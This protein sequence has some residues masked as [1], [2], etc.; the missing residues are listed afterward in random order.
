MITTVRHHISEVIM[1][2]TFADERQSVERALGKAFSEK[3]WEFL[4]RESYVAD[5]AYI[6]EEDITYAV[7]AARSIVQAGTDQRLPRAPRP[8]RSDREECSRA[9]AALLAADAARQEDVVGLRARVGSLLGWDHLEAWLDAQVDIDGRDRSSADPKVEL[10]YALPTGDSVRRR[11]VEAVGLL[12]E[13][14]HVSDS[15]ANAYGWQEAQ[16]L[17]WVLTGIVPLNARMHSDQVVH[18][19]RLATTDRIVLTIDPATP[20]AEVAAFYRRA[21][22]PRL[23]RTLSARQARLAAFVAERPKE[24]WQRRMDA[25]NALHP[26]KWRYDHTSN[27]IRD[28]ALAR[29]RLLRPR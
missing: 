29:D 10:A 7:N 1:R 21:R 15:L 6:S 13:L 25:W 20:A 24:P 11:R 18:S 14:A 19:P 9:I 27:M 16:A 12:A 22:G 8:R 17:V 4:V 3:L 28:A 5:S 2:Y 26:T 23:G